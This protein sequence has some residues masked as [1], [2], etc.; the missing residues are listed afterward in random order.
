MN[1]HFAKKLG[2]LI[3]KTKVSTQKING[4]RL[5]TFDMV[6]ALFSMEDKKRKS[7]FFEESFLLADISINIALDMPFLTLTNDEIEFISYY[8][9]WKTYIIAEIV[10]T[11]K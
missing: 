6:I 1:L 7:R 2:L 11:I 3:Y 9:Y 8:T 4:F 5:V 10:P